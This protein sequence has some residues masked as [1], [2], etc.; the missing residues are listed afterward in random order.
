MNILLVIY[1]KIS[2]MN[3][4]IIKHI[5]HV[6]KHAVFNDHKK[7]PL[8]RWALKDNKSCIDRSIMYSNEDHCG[9]CTGYIE[10]VKPTQEINTEFNEEY[11]WLIGATADTT[12]YK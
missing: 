1:H 3:R 7:V 8:G 4:L 2:T 10:T 5:R 12:K 9:V 6:L 11:I